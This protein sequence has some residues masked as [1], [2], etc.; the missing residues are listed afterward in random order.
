VMWPAAERRR[1]Q[2]GY[3]AVMRPAAVGDALTEPL[4]A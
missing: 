1:A 4:G 3:I 2:S